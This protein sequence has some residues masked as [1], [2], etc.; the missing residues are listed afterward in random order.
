M[1]SHEWQ[2]LADVVYPVCPECAFPIKQ[3]V[4]QDEH[5]TCFHPGCLA[6]RRRR[7]GVVDAPP[8]TLRRGRPRLKGG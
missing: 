4:V 3:R 1:V 6:R 2:D 7:A 5:G 8:P